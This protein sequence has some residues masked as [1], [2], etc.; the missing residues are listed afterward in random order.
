MKP[1]LCSGYLI[2]AADLKQRV[3]LKSAGVMFVDENGEGSRSEAKKNHVV[4]EPIY[5]DPSMPAIL[6]Y[7][8][9]ELRCFTF[10]EAKRAWDRLSEERKKVA[11]I[12]AGKNVYSAEEIDRLKFSGQRLVAVDTEGR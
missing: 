1:R 12:Q 2:A 3:T 8:G 10:G 9:R 7:A 11:T 5:V 4:T 6:R